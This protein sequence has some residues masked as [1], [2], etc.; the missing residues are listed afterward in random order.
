MSGMMP[1][2]IFLHACFIWS[3]SSIWSKIN[4]PYAKLVASAHFSIRHVLRMAANSEVASSVI[5]KIMINMVNGL[6]LLCLSNYLKLSAY[7]RI[8]ASCKKPVISYGKPARYAKKRARGE[9]L[10]FSPAVSFAVRL[11][12]GYKRVTVAP[13]HVRLFV[14]GRQHAVQG[15]RRVADAAR[16]FRLGHPGVDQVLR[17]RFEVHASH[18]QSCLIICQAQNIK[19]AVF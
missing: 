18:Y 3:C 9:S 12:H 10:N 19:D 2:A 5:K 7:L 11:V 6:F 15:L 8:H 16:D 17:E 13:D 14:S 1:N 4:A